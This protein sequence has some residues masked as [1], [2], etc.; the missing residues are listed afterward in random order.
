MDSKP[1]S[2]LVM[3]DGRRSNANTIADHIDAFKKYSRNDVY[4]YDP[5]GRLG[6][7]HLDLNEFDVVVLHYSVCVLWDYYLQPGFREKLAAYQGLKIQFIQDDYRR[8]ETMCNRVREMGIHLLFSLYAPDKVDLVYSRE[9]LPGVK[10]FTTLTGYVPEELPVPSATP[11]AAR[12][13]DVGYRGRELP[14]WLGHL[15]REKSAIV[16][17][18]LH[19]VPPGLKHNVSCKEKH[20]I[21]GA[22]WPKFLGSCRTMLGTE[23]GSSITDFDGTAETS[24]LE[25]LKRRPRASYEEVHTA[26]LERFEG[27]VVHNCISPRSFETAALRTAM[28]L[29]PGE[30]SKILQPW[31]HYIPLEKDFA[32]FSEVIKAIRD[33]DLLQTLIE[34][35]YQDLVADERYSYRA[36]IREFDEIL[37]RHT[38]QYGSASKSSYEKAMLEPRPY[39]PSIWHPSYWVWLLK[40]TT[41]RALKL[42]GL[43]Q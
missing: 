42:A 33:N 31:R 17:E 36:F 39:V 43:R 9:R 2:I 29:Y 20:R 22:R 4:Y 24:V 18:F 28:V 23:S 12:R 40:D 30:Y 21:Y 35:S 15:G 6:S 16:T 32:N 14:Y 8:V 38:G 27:N 5:L 26:V 11:L 37:D 34:N 1:L 3:A 13:Y 41:I 25:F 7:V 10:T 19:H